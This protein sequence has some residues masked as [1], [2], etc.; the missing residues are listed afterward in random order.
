VFLAANC[1]W[2]G[3]FGLGLDFQH[4]TALF[5]PTIDRIDF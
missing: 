5:R 1:L 4:Q 3:G 2:L